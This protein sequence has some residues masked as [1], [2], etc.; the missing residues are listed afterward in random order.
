LNCKER[1]IGR[2]EDFENRNGLIGDEKKSRSIP[3]VV[4]LVVLEIIT[5]G[6]R[7]KRQEERKLLRR[8]STLICEKI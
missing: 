6:S 2:K 4:N 3:Q 8:I 7:G 5:F 1:R